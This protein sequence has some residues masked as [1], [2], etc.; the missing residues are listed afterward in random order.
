MSPAALQ[1]TL[2]YCLCC[3]LRLCARFKDTLPPCLVAM[4]TWHFWEFFK[5]HSAFF[6]LPLLKLG[7]YLFVLI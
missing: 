7:S 5:G 4:A 2:H 3:S 1:E 6:V